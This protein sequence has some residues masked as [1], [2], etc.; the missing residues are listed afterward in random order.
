MCVLRNA[1]KKNGKVG[2]K[3]KVVHKV[4]KI[5]DYLN[6]SNEKYLYTHIQFCDD[7]AIHFFWWRC[8]YDDGERP[9]HC[10][11]TGRKRDISTD[12]KKTPKHNDEFIIATCINI[13]GN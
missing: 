12:K 10:G 11:V 4:N 8:D 1:Q 3:Q 13:V 6:N 9:A 5:R 2:E 7:H